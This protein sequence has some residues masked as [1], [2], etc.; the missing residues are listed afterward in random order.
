MKIQKEHRLVAF[1]MPEMDEWGLE[2]INPNERPI[3]APKD[4]DR[5][6]QFVLC[7][8]GPT[9]QAPGK[10]MVYEFAAILPME[11]TLERWENIFF[12]KHFCSKCWS[13]KK[14]IERAVSQPPLYKEDFAYLGR[15]AE[16]E[17]K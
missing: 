8:V 15:F 17:S 2:Q 13:D 12:A 14:A 9:R 10:R 5:K 16:Q 3:L 4:T 1:I 11:G 7:E 6:I